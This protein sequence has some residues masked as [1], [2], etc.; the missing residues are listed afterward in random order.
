VITTKLLPAHFI[1]DLEGATC[2]K[3]FPPNLNVGRV[4]IASMTY[5][6]DLHALAAGQKI[7]DKVCP[8]GNEL[9]ELNPNF[10]DLAAKDDEENLSEVEPFDSLGD[11]V[12]IR[13]VVT[14]VDFKATMKVFINPKIYERERARQ[15]EVSS[16]RLAQEHR[17]LISA[18]RQQLQ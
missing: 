18:E 9:V 5:E 14:G 13:K 16:S 6:S 11:F 12:E 8:I 1:L 17:E 2:D 7:L 3:L 15:A 10:I 4:V